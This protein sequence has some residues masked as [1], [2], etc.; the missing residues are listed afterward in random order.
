MD[1][2]IVDPV[3]AFNVRRSF[4]FLKFLRDLLPE[5]IDDIVTTM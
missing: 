1:E 4:S 5:H 2:K 3:N